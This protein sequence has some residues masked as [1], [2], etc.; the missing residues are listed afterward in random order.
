MNFKTIVNPPWKGALAHKIEVSELQKVP[1]SREYPDVFPEELPGIPAH[2]YIEFVIDLVTG[3]SPISKRP[4]RMAANELA[5]MKKQIH[6]LQRLS[7]PVHHHGD[8]TP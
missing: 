7:V 6:E 4:Y 2:R 8:V 5:E 3:T 1:I